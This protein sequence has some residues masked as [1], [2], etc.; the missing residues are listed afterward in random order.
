[1]HSIAIVIW[2]FVSHAL[3]H[4]M[5]LPDADADL[6]WKFIISIL[7]LLLALYQNKKGG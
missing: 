3:Y 5:T 1:M 4:D 7:L 2:L 6:G